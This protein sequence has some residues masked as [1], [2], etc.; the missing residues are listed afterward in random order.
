MSGY[1]GEMLI[2]P[3]QDCSGRYGRAFALNRIVKL[4]R[5]EYEEEL[6]HVVEPRWAPAFWPRTPTIG[7]RTSK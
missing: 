3:S 2:R 7:W 6:L 4:T 1:K 5:E